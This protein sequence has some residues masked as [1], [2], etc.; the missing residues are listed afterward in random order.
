MKKLLDF[1]R[2][3]YDSDHTGKNGRFN[4]GQYE[5]SDA[6]DDVT[7]LNT[8]GTSDTMYLMRV[9]PGG[10]APARLVGHKSVSLDSLFFNRK[11]GIVS[12]NIG[13]F[14]NNNTARL[15]ES[16]CAEGENDPA[17]V[18]DIPVVTLPKDKTMKIEWCTTMGDDFIYS[19]P[20]GKSGANSY[21]YCNGDRIR[22]RWDGVYINFYSLP[23][24]VGTSYCI[25]IEYDG[26]ASGADNFTATRENLETGAVDT[27]TATADI[28]GE[29]D[30]T[31]DVMMA[32][33]N[34]ILNAH[35]DS[36]QWNQ[37]ITI[38]GTL[39][40]YYPLAGSCIDI[41]GN[42]NHGT[43]DG[44]DLLA[45]QPADIDGYPYNIKNG[46]RLYEKDGEDDLYVPIHDVNGD[47]IDIT[48]GT[49]IPAGYSLAST[50]PAGHWHNGA[51]TKVLIGTNGTHDGTGWESS[52]WIEDVDTENVFHSGDYCTALTYDQLTTLDENYLTYET[53][54]NRFQ[55]L[56]IYD[57]TTSLEDSFLAAVVGT[58]LSLYLDAVH[59]VSGIDPD[60][61]NNIALDFDFTAGTV[62]VFI[63]GSVRD[64]IS[65]PGGFTLSSSENLE[66][67]SDE[68]DY[69]GQATYQ[70][71]EIT[72]EISSSS[73]EIDRLNEIQYQTAPTGRVKHDTSPIY[74]RTQ[75]GVTANENTISEGF[76]ENLP[77]WVDS[78][79]FRVTT[80]TY[81]DK[82]VKVIECVTGG[83][84][85]LR[86]EYPDATTWSMV[87]DTG[88]GYSESDGTGIVSGQT[89]TLSAGDK[90]ILSDIRGRYGLCYG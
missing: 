12:P 78:G 84:F 63:N 76:I 18:I 50:H 22:I 64:T 26:N 88:S 7:G 1:R 75:W 43:N 81:G 24:V 83:S 46:F 41:S 14:L 10:A 72:D 19:A 16:H 38:D 15:T 29:N 20:F 45:R 61:W 6:V 71:I 17:Q 86:G 37:K 85:E 47:E 25:T 67:G 42:G 35:S 48:V 82:T 4:A 55:N 11:S 77:L 44:V 57:L 13:D 40:R 65:L 5:I 30:A 32:G 49:D 8:R 59:T 36:K 89:F 51:E 28:S 66:L 39:E 69:P 70:Y 53:E 33:S 52:T 21:C 79:S 68:S 23:C 87:V 31:F 34:G 80:D 27:E 74:F 73:D 3:H 9:K 58:E 62:E 2:R 60:T 54:T 56:A 90:I